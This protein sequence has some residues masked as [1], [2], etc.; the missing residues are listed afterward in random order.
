MFKLNPKDVTLERVAMRA[1]YQV[2]CSRR[3]GINKPPVTDTQD[4]DRTILTLEVAKV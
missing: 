3:Y 2:M 4:I 1:K